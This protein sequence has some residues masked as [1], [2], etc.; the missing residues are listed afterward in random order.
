MKRIPLPNESEEGWQF[1]PSSIEHVIEAHL[2]RQ[3][4]HERVMRRSGKAEPLRFKRGAFGLSDAEIASIRWE[5]VLGFLESA[6]LPDELRERRAYYRDKYEERIERFSKMPQALRDIEIAR[7]ADFC[8]VVLARECEIAIA[9][10]TG[11]FADMLT[12]AAISR[13]GRKDFPLA[14]RAKMWTECLEF[15]MS[16]NPGLASEWAGRAWGNDRREEALPHV[17]RLGSTDEQRK[18]SN[19]FYQPFCNKLQSRLRRASPAWLDEAE[20]RITLRCLLSYAPGRPETPEDKSKKAVAILLMATPGLTAKQV[21]GKLDAS[22]E[23]SPDS[24]PI[25]A[26]WKRKGARSWI[27]GYEHFPNLVQPYISKVKRQFAKTAGS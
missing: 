5:A 19:K 10:T 9:R 22:N 15:A 7:E 11:H 12:Q 3:D 2:R 26:S 17:H 1:D 24:A 6:R 23:R 21:C 25:P 8:A 20:R 4:G 14:L 18:E 13:R 16:L 27:D